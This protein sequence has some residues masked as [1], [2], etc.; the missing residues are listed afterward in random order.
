M[1]KVLYR[2]VKGMENRLRL[3]SE[4]KLARRQTKKSS[5]IQMA[6]RKLWDEYEAGTLSVN[7]LLKQVKDIYAAP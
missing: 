6:I 5:S 1:V 2:E 3:V 7:R 4:K